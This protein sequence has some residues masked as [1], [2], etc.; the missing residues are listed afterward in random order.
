MK[1]EPMAGLIQTLLMRGDHALAL[2]EAEKILSY[3]ESGTLDGTEEPLRVYHTCYLALKE[4]GDPRSVPLL[5]KAGELL[6]TQVL[7]LRDD[8]SRRMFVENVPWRLEIYN[9]CKGT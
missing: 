4:G 7:K 6:E 9:A 8:E 5:H 1:T 2:V 3:L